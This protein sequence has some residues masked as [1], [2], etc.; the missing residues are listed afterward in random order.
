VVGATNEINHIHGED[1]VAARNCRRTGKLRMIASDRKARDGLRFEPNASRWI[2]IVEPV[3]HVLTD[4]LNVEAEIG[5]SAF[6]D[7]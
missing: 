6:H 3:S 5:L 2:G 7:D 4:W 1:H